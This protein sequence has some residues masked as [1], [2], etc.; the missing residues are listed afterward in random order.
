[1]DTAV[2]L[3]AL[4]TWRWVAESQSFEAWLGS[5]APRLVAGQHLVAA[6]TPMTVVRVMA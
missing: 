1:M 3:Q 5:P 4:R 2:F 6:R